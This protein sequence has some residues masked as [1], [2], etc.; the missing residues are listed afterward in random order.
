[1]AHG[2]DLAPLEAAV[3]SYV[4]PPSGCGPTVVGISERQATE[5]GGTDAGGP[6]GPGMTAVVGN[7]NP[8]VPGAELSPAGVALL[9]EDHAS[10]RGRVEL[11]RIHGQ[12][13]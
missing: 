3:V 12:V 11:P 8:V 6:Y 4:H 9:D 1:M 13:R 7:R 2:L 5:V 10:L